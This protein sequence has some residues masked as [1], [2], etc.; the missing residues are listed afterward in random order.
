[1]GIHGFNHVS[2][3]QLT[4]QQQKDDFAKAKNKLVS[5]FSDPNVRLFLP[6]LNEFNSGTIKAMAENKLDIFSTSYSSERATTNTYKVSNSFETDNSIIQ[7]S[8]VTV[9]DNNA[10]QYEKR[11]VY[12]VPFDISL[13]AM[14]PPR[15]TLSGQNLVDTVVSRTATQIANTGFAVITLHPSDVA[16]YNSATGSWSNSVDNAKFQDFKNILAALEAK[17]YDFSFM[18]DGTPAPF[19]QVVPGPPQPAVLT[20]NTIVN[21]GWGVDVT[22]TGKLSDS[23]S[24]AALGG[25]AITFKG[26]GAANLP[27]VTTNPD[28]TFTAKGKAPF[29]GGYRMASIGTVCW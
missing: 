23:A 21:V 28:G 1:M 25:E 5:L 6:P 9:F 8:E 11:R 4:E 18:S 17:G 3:S 12:D 27:S 10:G 19:S 20:L 22:V 14:I 2:H 16:P 24:G 26:T 7:L 29:N 15:G 13:L